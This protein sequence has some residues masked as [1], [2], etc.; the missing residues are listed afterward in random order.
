MAKRR[1]LIVVIA[2]LAAMVWAVVFSGLF[3]ANWPPVAAEIGRERDAGVRGCANRYSEPDARDRCAVLFD[4]Q[5]VMDFN[6]AIFTRLLIAAGPLAGIGLWAL[7]ARRRARSKAR[8][9]G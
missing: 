5:Y 2:A 6:Q 8:S 4:T 1:S 9:R 7:F 3:I